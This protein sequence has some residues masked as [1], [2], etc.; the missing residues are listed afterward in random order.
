MRLLDVTLENPT[1]QVRSKKSEQPT[2]ALKY[3]QQK[4][5]GR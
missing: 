3:A 4:I 5:Q 2:H 1:H